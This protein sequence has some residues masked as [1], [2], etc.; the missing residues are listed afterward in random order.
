V[1]SEGSEC[2][3]GSGSAGRLQAPYRGDGLLER[4]RAEADERLGKREESRTLFAIRSYER[5][6]SWSLAEKEGKVESL[7]QR[8]ERT[9]YRTFNVQVQLTWYREVHF[10]QAPSTAVEILRGEHNPSHGSQGS[11]ADT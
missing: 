4:E 3:Q 11:R 7:R 9:A 10:D 6:S 1:S 2:H 5:L 8:L